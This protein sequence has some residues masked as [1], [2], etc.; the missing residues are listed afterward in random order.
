MDM[1]E[2]SINSSEHTVPKT[3]ETQSE[4]D[5]QPFRIPLSQAEHF[6]RQGFDGNILIPTSM[7]L[8]FN[9]LQVDVHGRHPRKRMLDGTTRTYYV[10]DG[11]GT[12]T[13]SSGQGDQVYQVTIGDV[14][15]IPAGGEYE[16]E[17]VMTL[18]EFNV[19]PDQSFQDEKLE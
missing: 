14:F 5:R 15:V 6:T 16:Y 2:L 7:G 12:F 9:A 4:H 10:V 13:L 3:A 17:G 18:F 19:S 1:T 11:T 8:G